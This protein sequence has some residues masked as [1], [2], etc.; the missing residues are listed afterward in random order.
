M[1]PYI[2]EE[3]KRDSLDVTVPE[4]FIIQHKNICNPVDATIVLMEYRVRDVIF[5]C[6]L[7]YKFQNVIMQQLNVVMVG[8]P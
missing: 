2:L 3:T 4:M 8:Y 7:M 5:F 6:Q 1:I